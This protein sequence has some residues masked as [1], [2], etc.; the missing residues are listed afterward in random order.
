M[1]IYN[2]AFF[3]FALFY[4]P[5]FFMKLRQAEKPGKLL[6][7]RFGVFEKS[8]GKKEG[9]TLWLHAVSVGEVMA[10][11]RFTELFLEKFPGWNIVLTTVTPTGQ[12]IAAQME[13]L[14]LEAHYFPFDFDFLHAKFIERFKP[15]LILLAE[16]EIWPNMIIEAGRKKIPVGIINARL[17]EKSKKGYKRAGFLLGGLFRRLDFVLA[18]SAADRGRFVELGVPAARTEVMGNLK[19]DNQAAADSRGPAALKAEWG[20]LPDEL[21]W[22]AGSTHP[23]EEEQLLQVF[24]ELRAGFPALKLIL[25]P[26][27]IERAGSILASSKSAGL[28]AALASAKPGQ[29]SF[30]VLVLDRMGVL[31][32]LYQLA[33]IVFMGGSLVPHGGQNP[34]EAAFFQKPVLYGP[35]VFNFQEVYEKLGQE[36]GVVS[37]DGAAGLKKS[38]EGLLADP[39]R[40]SELGSN[41]LVAVRKLQG[42][43]K[44]HVEWLS[45]FLSSP[46]RTQHVSADKNLFPA[47]S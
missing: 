16:T 24:F 14:R 34:I 41:A 4:M 33:E 29:G 18:Q 36:N 21:V 6:R 15:A 3:V 37:V 22:I 1:W 40:R 28:R 32:S 45:V 12:K 17:S 30:D 31:R 26:R 43:A 38:L 5:V 39:A 23:G 8:A 47:F 11:R 20:F 27:H 10:V 25:A 9:R 7:E 13:G 42:A 2:L 44:R 35:H 19:F 46:E